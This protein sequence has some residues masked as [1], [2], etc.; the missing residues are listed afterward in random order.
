MRRPSGIAYQELVALMAQAF[1]PNAK[2]QVGEWIEGPDGRLDMD[3]SIRGTLDGTTTLAVIECKDFDVAKTGKVGRP[4]VDALDSKRHDLKADIVLICSNSGFTQDALNKA[5]R[6]G[7][8]AISVLAQG[9]ERVKI[10]IEQEIYFRRVTLSERRFEY[11]GPDHHLL[12]GMDIVDLPKLTYNGHSVNSWMEWRV[13]SIIA[14]NPHLTSS[15]TA[16]FKF[17][18]PTEFDFKGQKVV[19]ESV[20]MWVSPLKVRWYSQTVQ[21]DARLAMYDYLRGRL[22]FGAGRNELLIKGIDFDKGTPLDAAPNIERGLNLQSGE[23]DVAMVYFE[24]MSTTENPVPSLDAIVV[25]ED[26]EVF[27]PR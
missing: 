24:G 21:L 11:R 8:G 26:L 25:P 2:V 16:S 18:S 1:D 7:I 17:I 14:A 3:V 27:L 5:R 22:R 13:T 12:S 23:V 10:V 4:F 19:L 20:S 15:F 9:D 6:K